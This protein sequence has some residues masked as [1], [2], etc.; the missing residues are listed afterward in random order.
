M[1][2]FADLGVWKI[3]IIVVG[4][5]IL[6]GGATRLPMFAKGLGQ[7]VRV[8]RKEMHEVKADIAEDKDKER[9]GTTEPVYQATSDATEGR[10]TTTGPTPK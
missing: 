7:S 2:F 5:L 1:P 4:A 3:V 6:F 8:F 10:S 9:A